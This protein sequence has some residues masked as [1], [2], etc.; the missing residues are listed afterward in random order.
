LN[1]NQPLLVIW[2]PKALDQTRAE[3]EGRMI[4]LRYEVLA[5]S[6]DKLHGGEEALNKLPK[7]LPCLVL[8]NPTEVGLFAVVPPS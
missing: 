4:R 7:D 1:N 5:R 8:V 2:W 6:G 3:E